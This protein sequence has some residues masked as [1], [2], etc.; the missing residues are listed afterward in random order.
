MTILTDTSGSEV[1]AALVDAR[2]S[3]GGGA[4]SLALTLVVVAEA[5]AIDE[6]TKAACVAAAAHPCRLILVTRQN[7]TDAVHR[8]DA[9]ISVDGRLGPGE[10]VLLQMR[11]RL[12]LHAESV[13]LPLLAPDVPVVTWWQG[14]A[15]ERIAR[16]P[17]GVFSERRITDSARHNDPLV[18]L[19]Q[20]AVD[21]VPGDTDMA[22]S[23]ITGWRC[24]LADAL[25]AEY[26]PATKINIE[27]GAGNASVALLAGWLQGRL[28][29]TPTIDSAKDIKGISAVELTLAD[30]TKL[31]IQRTD[32]TATVN[33][34]GMPKR[35]LP[36]HRLSIGEALAEELRHLDPDQPYASALAIATGVDI[37]AARDGEIGSRVHEWFDPAIVS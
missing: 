36:L 23:R 33:R 18:G 16:D 19:R 12:A 26:I 32:G 8:L 28:G 29:V 9:E 31:S 20:R 5:E 1:L 27:A 21:Y 2:N 22:W 35:Q 14:P 17:L 10:A 25:D 24:L 13:T 3:R 30:G 11:G 34:T 37:A 15:P 7:P 6:A 4:S